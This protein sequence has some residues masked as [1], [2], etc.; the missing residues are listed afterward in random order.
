MKRSI[1][2]S[3]AGHRLAVKS[4]AAET[5]VRS[6]AELVDR[7]IRGM[8]GVKVPTYELAVLAALSIADDLLR[9]RAERRSLTK[10]IRERSERALRVLDA[11]MAVEEKTA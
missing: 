4:D 11:A 9:E 5:Y 8:A 2:V 6:L 7:K 1:S 3:I 10:K